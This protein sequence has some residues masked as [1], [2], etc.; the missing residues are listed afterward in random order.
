[1]FEPLISKPTSLPSLCHA[2]HEI[3]VK[4]LGMAPAARVRRNPHAGDLVAKVVE[5]NPTGDE[6]NTFE[7]IGSGG[8]LRENRPLKP[9]CHSYLSCLIVLVTA[10]SASA[11][12]V[13]NV[14]FM[15]DLFLGID[16]VALRDRVRESLQTCARLCS[17]ILREVHE[18]GCRQRSRL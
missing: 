16:C 8:V 9:V 12:Y 13:C 15:D 11:L 10:H 7:N 2:A 1:M 5:P 4:L 6:E 14:F 18:T 17:E 3:Q